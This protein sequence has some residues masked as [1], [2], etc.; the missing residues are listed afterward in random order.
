MDIQCDGIVR[1][2]CR[3][4]NKCEARKAPGGRTNQGRDLNYTH[5]VVANY[6]KKSLSTWAHGCQAKK[7]QFNGRMET[8][9]LR[10]PAIS[11]GKDPFSPRGKN[12]SG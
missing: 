4:R 12:T 10:E 7:R 9:T 3:M 11:D 5:E 6:Q 8:V 1:V 2:R